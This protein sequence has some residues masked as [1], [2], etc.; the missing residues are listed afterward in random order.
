[1]VKESLRFYEKEVLP[2]SQKTLNVIRVAYD[3]GEQQLLDVIA[4]Q[5]RLIEIQQ[6][7]IEVQKDYYISLIEL[8]KA[9]GIRIN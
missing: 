9:L 5:R 1:M 3:L 4:E 8:E 7:Y 6:Q 2:N